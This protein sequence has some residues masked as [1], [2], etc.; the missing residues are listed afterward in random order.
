MLTTLLTGNEI[1]IFL[2]PYRYKYYNFLFHFRNRLS[3]KKPRTSRVIS[4][5]VYEDVE[6]EQPRETSP[7]HERPLP[8]VPSTNHDTN[9]NINHNTN[10]DEQHQDDDH[11]GDD[12][13]DSEGYLKPVPSDHDAIVSIYLTTPMSNVDDGYSKPYDHIPELQRLLQKEME[14]HRDDNET[15]EVQ[16]SEL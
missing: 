7:L 14:S 13:H 1:Q 2:S 5:H 10:R 6:I 8:P 12:R 16:T 11:H 3:R 4:L 9:H 15:N